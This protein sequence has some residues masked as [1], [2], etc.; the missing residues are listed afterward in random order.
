MTFNPKDYV[1]KM[2]GKDYLE[3]KWRIVWFRDTHP[4][5][6]I[7]TDLVSLDPVVVKATVSV[8]GNVLGTGYGTPKMMGVAKMRPFEGAE[9]A[10]IGR[11][12]AIAGFGTQFT[13]ED[14]EEHL[15]DAP[16]EMVN[17]AKKLGGKVTW[18]EEH[19]RAAQSGYDALKER[20]HALRWLELTKLDPAD[21]SPEAVFELA[22]KYSGIR[23]GNKDLKPAEVMKLAKEN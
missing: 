2:Q 13:G 7:T 17:E 22:D 9:T 20:P 10:A 16:V 15:A 19:V 18:S 3:V 12:L 14:E 11:A 5:G 6:A 21:V 1:M 8:D 23:D 4:N